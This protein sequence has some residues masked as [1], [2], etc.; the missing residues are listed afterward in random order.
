M[1][2][3]YECLAWSSIPFVDKAFFFNI[4][5]S[6]EAEAKEKFME[7]YNSP[8]YRWA[9][10]RVE[11][12]ELQEDRLARIAAYEARRNRALGKTWDF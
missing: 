8:E 2:K 3:I 5:A 6:S 7:L 4:E 12:W 11:R 1:M 10:M 9:K